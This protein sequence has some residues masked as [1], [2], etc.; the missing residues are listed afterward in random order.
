LLV[1]SIFYDKHSIVKDA[2]AGECDATRAEG[3][4]KRV[5]ET[6]IRYGVQMTLHVIAAS[7]EAMDNA[8]RTDRLAESEISRNPE[9]K[10]LRRR[11]NADMIGLRDRCRIDR[12]SPISRCRP[13]WPVDPPDCRDA[14]Y[15]SQAR[16]SLFGPRVRESTRTMS[17]APF[18]VRR[19]D[20]ASASW[21]G[22]SCSTQVAV[23]SPGLARKGATSTR[24]APTA[25]R[26]CASAVP[27]GIAVTSTNPPQAAIAA[28]RV[29]VWPDMIRSP[30]TARPTR[31]IA[32]PGLDDTPQPRPKF[33]RESQGK[34]R[35]IPDGPFLFGN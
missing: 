16:L 6:H 26:D 30:I 7:E 15:V 20:S 9:R 31:M 12:R 5:N 34:N 14:A 23:G 10:R 28:R 11:R 8:P 21:R 13:H 24:I 22:S 29:N 2:F 27:P 18:G 17:V 3:L 33:R 32:A 1:G 35:P 4:I 25:T 19:P